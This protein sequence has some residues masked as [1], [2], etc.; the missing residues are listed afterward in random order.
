MP[1]ADSRAVVELSVITTCLNEEA[2]IDALASRTLETFNRMNIEAELVIVDDGSTDNTW[3]LIEA[4]SRQTPRIRGV[5]HEEN[6]G[7]E[8]GWKSG[9]DAAA[10]RLVCL[11]DSDLQ[12]APEDIARLCDAHRRHD[13]DIVQGSRR[14]KDP[15]LTRYALSRGLNLMLN[16]AFGMRLIDNKSGF[17]LTRRDALAR[18]LEHRYTYRYFQC[19]I[20][21]SAHAKGYTFH[22]IETVFHPRAGG[23]SFLTDVPWRV[24]AVTFAE[25][26]KARLE[27]KP[28]RQTTRPTVEPRLQTVVE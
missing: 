4:W 11:I 24:I 18:I 9:L 22:Q 25:L 3:S 10:G 20:A 8:G 16:L 15:P 17:I 5:R 19:F 27:F 14:P 26:I 1:T 23:K 2:N 6:L 12:N 28:P 21:A 13:C 7:I